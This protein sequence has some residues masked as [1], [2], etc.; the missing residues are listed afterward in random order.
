M[1]VLIVGNGG[2][3]NALAWKTS[4]SD[5]VQK[6][7]IAPGNGGTSLENK[8]ENV[9][10]KADNLKG[11]TDFAK[12]KKV[13]LVVIG[14]EI[15]LALG[16]T[17][18]LEAEGFKVFGP[19]KAASEM[20]A[21]K[22]FAKEIMTAAGVPTAEYGE[23]TDFEPAVKYIRE[24]GAPIVVKAD[25]L[26]AGKGVTVAMTEEEAIN[27]IDEILNKKIF[28]KDNTKAVVEEFLKGQEVSYL[29]MTDGDTIIPLASAQDHKAVFDGDKGPNTGGMG[30]YSPAP[31]IPDGKY[32][33]VT[34]VV[35]RP[36]IEELKK[37]GITYKGILYAGLMVSDKGDIK[38]LEYN[39]R[40]GDPETQVLLPK[41]RSDLVSH[42]LAVSNGTLDKEKV[43][44][45]E[46]SVV[47][48]VMASGGYPDEYK[49]GLRITGIEDA[50][51]MEEVQVFH[52]GTK[53]EDGVIKT[54]GGRVLNV[55]AT[56]KDLRTAL[57][58]AYRAVSKIRFENAHYRKD[59]GHKALK[60]A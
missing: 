43:E 48:V 2:R 6:I 1:I 40:F 59:I 24:K 21:S 15:P 45:D 55:T 18:M 11:I 47:T 28:G 25:G 22:A 56:G 44:W 49:T 29:V 27:A 57:D 37:R 36:I 34:E 35:A 12:E 51:N 50:N 58:K 17:D 26:A 23:F 41:M 38:V 53:E 19:N 39:C 7:Y 32:E 3:E 46:G 8:C 16:L 33:Q 9:P 14:P 13:D 42:M 5:K 20:E 54:A 52:A 30:A 60:Q 31:V 4:R 10:L